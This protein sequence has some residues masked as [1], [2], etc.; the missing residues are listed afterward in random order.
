MGVLDRESAMVWLAANLKGL[1]WPT[2]QDSVPAPS[3]WGWYLDVQ[4]DSVYLGEVKGLLRERIYQ[5]AFDTWYVQ[6]THDKLPS[7]LKAEAQR[8]VGGLGGSV[9][10]RKFEESS[11]TMSPTGK[12]DAI[13]HPKHYLVMSDI[14]AIDV[15]AGSMTEEMFRGYCLGNILKYRLRAGKKDALEQDIGKASEYEALFEK[16]KHLCRK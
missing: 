4:M 5:S 9:W 10:Q 3:G 1:K 8:L 7:D 13:K 14:E 6:S 12:Y 15:I 2:L 11:P 16:W